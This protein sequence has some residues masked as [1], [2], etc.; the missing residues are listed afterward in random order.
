MAPT[1]RVGKM[2]YTIRLSWFISRYNRRRI[3]D[4]GGRCPPEHLSPKEVVILEATD[5]YGGWGLAP[6]TDDSDSPLCG[7][8]YASA[9]TGH[10]PDIP[11]EIDLDDPEVN[12]VTDPLECEDDGT[13]AFEENTHAAEELQDFGCDVEGTDGPGITGGIPEDPHDRSVLANEFRLCDAF[14]AGATRMDSG[15]APSPLPRES[16]SQSVPCDVVLPTTSGE[17]EEQMKSV[18]GDLFDGLP[19]GQSRNVPRKKALLNPTAPSC[20]P[21][22]FNSV[23]EQKWNEILAEKG[24]KHTGTALIRE[25]LRSYKTWRLGRLR[26]C[27]PESEPL[28]DVSY[29]LADKWIRQ[30]L[31]FANTPYELG[32][33]T[34]ACAETIEQ[35]AMTLATSS[36]AAAASF[37]QASTPAKIPILQSEVTQGPAVITAQM[38]I[39]ER[40][41][42]KS[43]KKADGTRE[44]RSYK[45]LEERANSSTESTSAKPANSSRYMCPY[46]KL[47]LAYGKNAHVYT[48]RAWRYGECPEAPPAGQRT[49]QARQQRVDEQEGMKERRERAANRLK[50][51]GMSPDD[52]AS[53]ADG[54]KK[55]CTVCSKLWQSKDKG[56][57]HSFIGRGI[58]F[59]PFADDPKILKEYEADR[60]RRRQE[61]DKAKR[62]RKK[63]KL[64]EAKMKNQ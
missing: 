52:P 61:Q 42:E 4:L 59:C 27:F 19:T 47:P 51:L 14:I 48:A 33:Y 50:E 21:P 34:A 49:K 7:F 60:K 11:D 26:E 10:S 29:G 45:K 9:I 24:I 56:M 38:R 35:V 8:E 40:C 62:A 32:N 17:L 44:K 54:R 37:P 58:C 41:H 6:E 46:C 30:Q 31:K 23:M 57:S 20:V 39:Q 12:A 1:T 43:A 18:S 53:M 36:A 16:S 28:F 3:T 25:C 64:E 5:L 55:I 15:I 63:Q 22:D 13:S 2:L